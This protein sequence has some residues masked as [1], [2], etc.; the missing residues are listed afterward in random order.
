[1]FL[2][3]LLNEIKNY[4]H[5]KDKA[6]ALDEVAEDPII[7][8]L[9]IIIFDKDVRFFVDVGKVKREVDPIGN[10]LIGNKSDEDLNRELLQ[11]LK[12]L[13]SEEIRGN[14]GVRQCIDYAE[15]LLDI[16]NQEMLYNILENKT[17][18][19]I[20]TTDINKLCKKF[21]I[22]VFEVMFA[23]RYDKAKK[24][25]WSKRYCIQPK[26]DGNRNIHKNQRCL[27]RTG[28]E[29][30]ALDIIKK[31]LQNYP[32]I[33]NFTVDGEIENDGSLEA[34]GAV[35]RKE[36]QAEN[37]IYTIFGIY[38][39][40]EWDS[41][42]FTQTYE[43]V[44][45]K[46]QEIIYY[47]DH[48]IRLIP[49]FYIS[50]ISEEEFHRLIEFYTQLFINQGYE[51]AVLKTL[52]HT[53]NPSTG[54][55]RSEDWLKIKPSLDSDGIVIDILEGEGDWKGTAGK[56][57]VNWLSKTFQVS[58][59]K[60]TKKQRKEIWLHKELYLKKKLEFKYQCL[61]EYGVPRHC[62]ATKFRESD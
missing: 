20:G 60:F 43:E 5:K 30:L 26:I 41:K 9:L 47:N 27:S 22:E 16:S 39:N 12:L 34:T 48:H 14:E 62:F 57:V 11:L 28:K 45:A 7:K 54:T 42:I 25:N 33:N 37:A 21:K 2:L 53:Y 8:E 24:V 13:A 3:S 29:F 55:R 50:A 38:P 46:M 44:L 10:I 56:F 18:L 35:R 15:Q 31:E 4:K 61:S 59:G 6:Y 49:T 58:P 1:M 36:E 40:D 52:D 19:G 23:L 32:G 51:G 17:R